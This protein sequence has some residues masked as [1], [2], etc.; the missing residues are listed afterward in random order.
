MRITGL[1]GR[2]RTDD[3]Q[4][5]NQ[6]GFWRRKY[7]NCTASRPC[8]RRTIESGDDRR[9]P[10]LQRPVHAEVVPRLVLG[11][12]RSEHRRLDRGK[13]IVIKRRSTASDVDPALP[14]L[15]V[16]VNGAGF[17]APNG[18]FLPSRRQQFP[19]LPRGE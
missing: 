19:L 11:G 15:S 4:N 18:R 6:T 7:L 2:T 13:G 8:C 3:L 9:K 5:L 1:S 17:L 16:E 12:L 10:S 14:H